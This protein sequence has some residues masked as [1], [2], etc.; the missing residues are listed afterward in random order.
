MTDT[1]P[2]ISA[3]H[4]AQ[5]LATPEGKDWIVF[6]ATTY[7]PAEGKV[8]AEEFL[9]AR[10]PG[11]RFFD[12]DVVADTETALPHMA[13]TQGRFARLVSAFGV[14][15]T[16][17]VVCYD[18]KGVFS[19]PR[20][21]WLFRLF[22][23]DRV[24]VLDGGLP[25]WRAAGFPIESGPPGPL[26][27]GQ[28][29]PSFRTRLLRG[30]GDMMANLASSRD[31]VLDARAAGRFQGIAPEPRP[32]LP[33]GHIPGSRSLPF[34]EILNPDQTLR[35]LV[36]LRQTFAACGIDGQK[37]VVCSCGSGMTAAVLALGMAV[38]GLPDAAIYDGSW[39][40][41]AAMPTAPIETGLG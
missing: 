7:M 24:S 22:G 33:S 15:N 27:P 38:A 30:F 10:L 20:A 26:S 14:S 9:K 18:Q 37:P 13:P 2:L 16:S 39:T 28:F 29:L 31:I 12:L 23:H 21:W 11:A 5:A 36:E 34:T 3:H 40:E 6:D 25:A 4:L 19:A 17:R 41:W 8:G 32:E 1:P 35:S